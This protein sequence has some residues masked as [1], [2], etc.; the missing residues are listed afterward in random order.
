MHC[1]G[2]NSF[3]FLLILWI[4]GPVCHAQK[5]TVSGKITDAGTGEYLQGVNVSIDQTYGTSTNHYGFYSLG[6]SMRNITLHYSYV[7][8]EKTGVSVFLQSDTII[9][10]AMN[11]SVTEIGEVVVQ[12]AN[13]NI[14]VP[15]ISKQQISVKEIKRI[16]GTAG[17]KDVLRSLQYLPGVNSANEGVNSLSV[18]GGSS[19]QNLVILDEA[20]IYNPNHA[21]SLFSAFNPDAIS[22]VDFYKAAF[23]ARYGGRLSSVMDIRMREGNKKKTEIRGGIG[24]IASRLSVEGPIRKDTASYMIAARYSYIGLIAN[25]YSRIENLVKHYGGDILKGNEIDFYDINVKLNYRIDPKNHLFLSGYMGN[26]NFYFKNFTDNY[27][28]KWSNKTATLRW[29]RIVNPRIFINSSFIF[30]Q[31]SYQYVLVQ[32]VRNFLWKA[33]MKQLQLKSDAEHYLADRIKLK[34]GLFASYL[35]SLPGSVVPASSSSQTRSFS[36]PRSGSLEYGTYA[37]GD[38][39]I[40][41]FLVLRAGLRVTSFSELGAKLVYQYDENMEN[42]TDSTLYSKGKVISRFFQAEPRIVL[43]FI[44]LPDMSVKASYNKVYQNLH[45]LSNSSVGMP[46]DIWVPSGKYIQPQSSE[47][48]A[49]AITRNLFRGAV[50]VSVEGYYKTINDIIDYKDNVDLFL[51]DKIERQILPGSAKGYG[52]EFFVNKKSGRLNGWVAYTLSRVRNRIEGIND[53]QPYPAKYDKPHNLRTTAGYDISP[54]WT[55]LMSFAY[56]SGSNM[57]LLA[58]TYSYY[59]SSFAYYTRRNGYRVPAY[60]QMDIS[61]VYRP[62]KGRRWKGEWV[63]A[64]NNVY[65]RRNVFSIYSQQ[66]QYNLDQTKVYKMYLYGILPSVTYNFSF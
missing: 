40:F 4:T 15:E 6:L 1:R 42:V 53:G 58:G 38:I 49:L 28:L 2:S 30:S 36:M 7:G 65:N 34:Y 8:Y 63:F 64:V 19:D 14:L 25:T 37:E 61:A 59:G 17:E 57:T 9:N 44:P 39:G 22:T 32:D 21:L 10:I 48:F 66:Y 26:D 45:L 43:N 13:N 29:N 33:D 50:E 31:Y 62:D 24:L 60:H 23:P 52:L 27:K 54:K 20:V 35:N 55:V 3:L 11:R 12:A 41:D 5:Y 46:T 16:T 18:R 56:T 51:N 47:Q